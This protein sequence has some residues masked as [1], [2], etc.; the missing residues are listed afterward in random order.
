M[1]GFSFEIAF[2]TQ[3]APVR[4]EVT[5]PSCPRLHKDLASGIDIKGKVSLDSADSLG[6]VAELR[7]VED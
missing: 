4:D 6:C 7:R 5:R 2:A 3:F 1:R